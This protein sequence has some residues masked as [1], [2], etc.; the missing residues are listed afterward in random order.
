MIS[1]RVHKKAGASMTHDHWG[2]LT[3]VAK[4]RSQNLQNSIQEYINELYCCGYTLYVQIY[5]S[6]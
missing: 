1:V 2:I 3:Q 5:M 6:L 4:R